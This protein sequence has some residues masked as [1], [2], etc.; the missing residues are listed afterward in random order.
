M[1]EAV[2]VPP[3]AWSTSQS[4][5]IW[6]SP[7]A[8]RSTT[9]RSERPTRRWISCVR[10]DGLPEV[11][12]RRVRSC[13]ARGSIEYSAVTQPLPV[14]RSQGGPFSSTV[15]AQSTLVSPNVTMQEPSA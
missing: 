14:P 6:R 4:T 7:I 9:A 5:T 10:P 13:V 8:V 2:R 3:S 12:S 15:A 11:T 1:I